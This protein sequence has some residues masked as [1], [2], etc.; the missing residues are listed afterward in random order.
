MSN[1]FKTPPFGILLF[2]ENRLEICFANFIIVVKYPDS[3]ATHGEADVKKLQA[4]IKR[5]V[6]GGTFA[7]F[8]PYPGH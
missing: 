7:K 6:P 4:A 5:W 3:Q 2:T 8:N 1:E